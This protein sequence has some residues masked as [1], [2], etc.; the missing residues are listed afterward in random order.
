MDKMG[1]GQ[2]QIHY[3]E[4]K[5]GGPMKLTEDNIHVTDYYGYDRCGKFHVE[6][7]EFDTEKEAVQL[8]QQILKNQD[9]IPPDKA[10]DYVMENMYDEVKEAVFEQEADNR[11]E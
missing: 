9:N 7:K 1:Q 2:E 5:G 4:T 3:Q 10:F 11:H 6:S 8:K